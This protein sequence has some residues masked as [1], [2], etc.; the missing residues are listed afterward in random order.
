ML[1]D[2][3]DYRLR[4]AA[5][6]ERYEA[7]K[8][9]SESLAAQ[10]RERVVK[11]ARIRRFMDD[12]RQQVNLIAAFDEHAWNTLV[13]GVTVYAGDFMVRFKDGSEIRVAKAFV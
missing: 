11:R 12:L 7:E 2:Q 9:R 4:Y 13:D 8:A 5:L 6:R 1:V 3:S 10:R